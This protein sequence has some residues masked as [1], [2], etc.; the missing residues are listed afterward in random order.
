VKINLLQKAKAFVY[1][2]T[3]DSVKDGINGGYFQYQTKKS[4]INVIS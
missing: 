1:S 3:K 4:I 2:D